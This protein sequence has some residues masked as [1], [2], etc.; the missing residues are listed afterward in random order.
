MDDGGIGEWGTTKN[1]GGLMVW[2]ILFG[3]GFRFITVLLVEIKNELRAMGSSSISSPISSSS[4]ES[5]DS[6]QHS[7]SSIE[8][9]LETHSI[10][11]DLKHKLE[12]I[13]SSLSEIE[14]NT[15]PRA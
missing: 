3:L 2:A 12:E 7:I 6:I 13:A 5:L 11:I 15:A 4:I 10:E 1:G 8:T 14:I 9:W